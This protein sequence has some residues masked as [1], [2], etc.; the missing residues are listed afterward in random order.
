MSRKK[1]SVF[2]DGKIHVC[3]EMCDTCI[4]SPG[5]LMHL[6]SGRVAE[7]VK[8][9]TRNESCIPCHKHLDSDAF[10][11]RGFFNKHPTAPLQIADRLGMV[12]FG[13]V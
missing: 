13:G 7:M 10:V 9:A 5:N 11:C 1:H 6:A 4:F 12:V 3:S 8:E 2:R